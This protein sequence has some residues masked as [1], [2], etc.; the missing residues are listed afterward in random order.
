MATQGP[1]NPGTMATDSVVGS[2]GWNNADNAKVSDDSDA[3][4]SGVFRFGLISY[5]LKATNFGFSIPSGATIDGIV[6]EIENAAALA[7]VRDN[8]VKIIK[9]DGSLGGEEKADTGTDWSLSDTYISY[10][11]A[12]DLWSESWDNTDINDIDFGVVISAK[13]PVGADDSAPTI[14][15]IRITVYYTELPAIDTEWTDRGGIST[16]YTNRTPV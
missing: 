9:S 12:N 3:T 4:T 14:D 11:D 7:G 5:Y 2:V 15:H 10:G 6:V 1:N 13:A 16:T 8:S